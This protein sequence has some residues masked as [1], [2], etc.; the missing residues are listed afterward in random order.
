MSLD[1]SLKTQDTLSGKRSVMKRVERIMVLK[2]DKRLDTSKKGALGL[3]KT[4]VVER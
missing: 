1:P 4:K 2:A 3:P